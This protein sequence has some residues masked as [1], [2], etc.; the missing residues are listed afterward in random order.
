MCDAREQ[1]TLARRYLRTEPSL[2]KSGAG[3][4]AV[5]FRRSEGHHV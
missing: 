3:F 5:H 4:A 2:F 1:F